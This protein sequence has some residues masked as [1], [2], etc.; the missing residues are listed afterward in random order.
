MLRVPENDNTSVKVPEPW[1]ITPKAHYKTTPLTRFCVTD[2]GPSLAAA[3]PTAVYIYQARC[4][5]VCTSTC[6][7]M[8]DL[9][10]SRD[11]SLFFGFD[12][13]R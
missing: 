12:I 10:T 1:T 7:P 3:H 9:S 11:G 13:L 4:E 5:V 8:P 2:A 6:A